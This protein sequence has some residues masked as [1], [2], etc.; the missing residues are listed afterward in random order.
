MHHACRRLFVEAGE[1]KPSRPVV[2][3]DVED[4]K[5]LQTIGSQMTA[6]LS[7]LHIC[8]ALLTRNIIFFA[9]VGGSVNRW[10]YCGR[11]DYGS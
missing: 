1:M 10:D 6:G 3:S 2:L 4:P 9:S 5:F 8:R 11:T 7:V